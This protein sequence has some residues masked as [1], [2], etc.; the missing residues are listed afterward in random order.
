MSMSESK[1]AFCGEGIGPMP[2]EL[3]RLCREI[4]EKLGSKGYMLDNYLSLL[5]QQFTAT[6]PAVIVQMG[7]DAFDRLYDICRR[8]V[9][10][11]APENEFTAVVREKI[12]SHPMKYSD[13]HT[14]AGLYTLLLAREY[15]VSQAANVSGKLE[16]DM[17]Q[18]ADQIQT[19][20][21]RLEMQ[22]VC[23]AELLD[24]LDKVVRTAW[25]PVTPLELFK[26]GYTQQMLYCM[27]NDRDDETQKRYL[28][29]LQE[30]VEKN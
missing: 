23:S 11:E 21:L 12:A 29:L 7:I 18:Y 25:Q 17:K 19:N 24:R 26:Q 1:G 8:T 28:S 27:A 14:C 2:L 30:E 22:S 16:K 15:F 9:I 6:G 3:T 20:E 10:G 5:A 13:E 4:R